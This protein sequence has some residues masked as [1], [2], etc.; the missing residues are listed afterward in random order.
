MTVSAL[1]PAS[2]ITLTHDDATAPQS[3]RREGASVLD[4]VARGDSGA[5]RE[6]IDQ[7][8]DL[9]WSI[10]RR[11]LSTRADI[12]E[13]VREIFVD[14][15]RNAGR[16]D[17][18]QG[19]EEVFI[20]MIARRRLIDRMRRAARD[21]RARASDDNVSLGWGDPGNAANACDE[22]QAARRAIMRL[23]PE[24]RMMLELGILQGSS[25]LEISQRLQ[26]PLATVNIMMTRGLIQVRELMNS[27]E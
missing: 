17:P 23:R 1:F 21:G 20:T 19:S 18:E 22:A 15:W 11:L 12:E 10:A 9:V 16:Y 7:F 3:R 13:A 25:H 24:L 14:V 8:G 26:M 6:C 27:R 5:A 2:L 4:R